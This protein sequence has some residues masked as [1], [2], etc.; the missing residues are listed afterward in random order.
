MYVCMIGPIQDGV[1]G[2]GK[3]AT[4]ELDCKSN[5]SDS[6]ILLSPG[7]KRF[8]MKSKRMSSINKE[9]KKLSSTKPDPPRPKVKPPVVPKPKKTLVAKHGRTSESDVSHEDK[10]S[11]NVPA[12]A[13]LRKASNDVSNR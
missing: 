3:E 5:Y 13:S 11:S 7:Q 2:F 1:A 12:K 8:S 9:Q 6:E 10:T 4:E